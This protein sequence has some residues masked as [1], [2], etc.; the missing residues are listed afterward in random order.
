MLPK[1]EEHLNGLKAKEKFE[2]T[3]KCEDAYGLAT[4]EALIKALSEQHGIPGVDLDFIEIELAHLEVIPYDIAKKHLI[5]PINV[6]NDL[7]HLA[8]ANPE[9]HKK[10]GRKKLVFLSRVIESPITIGYSKLSHLLITKVSGVEIN[11]IQGAIAN[12]RG[13]G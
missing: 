13:T 10:K 9:A 12:G 11:S 4:E 5:L 8:M 2:F 1:F 7:I 6:S 3:L